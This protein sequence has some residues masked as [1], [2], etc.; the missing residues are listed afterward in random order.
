MRAYSRHE[1]QRRFEPLFAGV[2]RPSSSHARPTVSRAGWTRLAAILPVLL[3]CL[4]SGG[5]ES[6]TPRADSPEQKGRTVDFVL[7]GRPVRLLL[8]DC[9][10]FHVPPNGEPKRVVTTDFY[11]MFSACQREEIS[12]DADHITVSLGRQAFGAGGCCATSGTWRSADGEHWE[13]RLKGRWLSPAEEEALREREA[14]AR[15]Q[16][17]TQTKERKKSQKKEPPQ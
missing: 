8:N 9:E 5:C 17:Q 11:P 7:H 16:A 3:L 2:S 6:E 1:T 4:V 13:R 12:A 15:E 14:A 10:V